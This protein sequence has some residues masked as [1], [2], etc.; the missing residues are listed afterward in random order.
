MPPT[1]PH[2][3]LEPRRARRGLWYSSPETFIPVR[4][5]SPMGQ[6]TD[7]QS[8]TPEMRPVIEELNRFATQPDVLD[9][10]RQ[11]AAD[12]RKSLRQN[13]HLAEAYAALDLSSVGCPVP[14]AIGSVRVVVTRGIGGATIERHANSTQYLL[15]LD[16]AMETHVHT[17]DGWRVDRYGQGN[18]AVLENRW[19]VVA[20]GV[21]HKSAAP[22]ARNWG[23][24][25]FH[26]AREVSDEYQ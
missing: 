23:V 25:A 9:A 22:G 24:V 1:P 6:T 13:P 8:I 26:S 12:A 2:A 3:G 16:G 15:A 4:S 14:A 7:N 18:P 17:P 21:W 20:P 19:H 5:G 11:A 10:L